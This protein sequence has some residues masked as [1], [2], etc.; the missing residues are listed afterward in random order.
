MKKFVSLL[1][2]LAMTLGMCSFAGASSVA[3]TYDVKIWVAENIVDLTKQQIEAFNASNE[4]GIVIN[5]TVEAVSEADLL[6]AGSVCPPGAG[7]RSDAAGRG[8]LRI[9]ADQ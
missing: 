8:R 6:R 9:R 2:A 4:L 7:R 3:G 1:L 5:P